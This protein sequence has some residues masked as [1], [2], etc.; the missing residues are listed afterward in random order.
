[1]LNFST[2]LEHGGG[3]EL[4]FLVCWTLDM[5]RFPHA[6]AYFSWETRTNECF[7]GLAVN[8]P[9]P[10]PSGRLCF[11]ART[12]I[13]LCE[14]GG[15]PGPVASFVM[16]F[17]WPIDSERANTHTHTHHAARL[18][19]GWMKLCKEDVQ[20]SSPLFQLTTHFRA[21]AVSESLVLVFQRV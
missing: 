19:T 1:M 10:T 21:N 15:F 18:F 8:P 3:G 11:H 14:L 12:F 17:R 6:R 13:K 20:I 9:A 7:S 5:W 2:S 4:T 16:L